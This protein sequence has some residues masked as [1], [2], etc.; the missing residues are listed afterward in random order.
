L[1]HDE[2]EQP[3]DDESQRKID[4][5]DQEHRREE[6]IGGAENLACG[7]IELGHRHEGCDRRRLELENG[8]TAQCRKYD[9]ERPWKPDT[10]QNGERRHSKSTRSFEFAFGHAG[11]GA[12]H[13]GSFIASETQR[14]GKHGIEETL[15]EHRPHEALAY[16]RYLREERTKAIIE[17]IELNEQRRTADDGAECRGEPGEW[18]GAGD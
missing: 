1:A 5:R 9:A 4:Q 11:K 18:P 3:R 6:I 2:V 14:E 17:N 15:P 13:D 7:A 10:A 16:P 12:L 8:F